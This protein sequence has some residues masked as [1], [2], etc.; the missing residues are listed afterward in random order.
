MKTKIFSRIQILALLTLPLAL[1]ASAFAQNA[2]KIKIN[3]NPPGGNIVQTQTSPISVSQTSL[4]FGIVEFGSNNSLAKILT[5]QVKNISQQKLLLQTRPIGVGNSFF[6]ITKVQNRDLN[7]GEQTTVD[8]ACGPHL[9]QEINE[10]AFLSAL[11]GGQ[12]QQKVAGIKLKCKGINNFARFNLKMT[13]T[14]SSDE[15]V[16]IKVPGHPVFSQFKCVT[17]SDNNGLGSFFGCD[18]RGI[19]KGTQIT[20]QSSSPPTFQG[21]SNPSGSITACTPKGPCSFTLNSDSELTA[22]FKPLPL[23]EDRPIEVGVRK[24]GSGDGLVSVSAQNQKPLTTEGMTSRDPA[25]K[26]TFPRGTKLLIQVTPDAKSKITGIK[27]NGN[28]AKAELC[29]DKPT[30]NL[31]LDGITGIVATFEPKTRPLP[32]GK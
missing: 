31:V 7:P 21:F 19:R 1:T 32:F 16:D 23:A 15:F 18:L 11:V 22:T 2:P 12:S 29:N 5:V 3:V 6:A 4:D 28:N 9:E 24:T 25:R 17:V 10:T 20:V 26:K 13:V 14:D 30:C 8:I 27:L